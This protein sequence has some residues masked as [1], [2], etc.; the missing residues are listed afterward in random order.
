[1]IRFVSDALSRSES[2]LLLLLV[3]FVPVV[4]IWV[5]SVREIV[6]N[7]SMP[8]RTK[9]IYT[10]LVFL[11]PVAGTFIYLVLRPSVEEGVGG[12]G[13]R[14]ERTPRMAQIMALVAAAERG[15][16]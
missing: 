1:M 16:N 11:M 9:W 2:T 5:Y 7:R 13:D 10:A 15:D 12:F 6:A 14:A 3:V 4:V 8:A